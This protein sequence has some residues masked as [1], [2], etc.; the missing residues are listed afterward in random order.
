MKLGP[1]T[2]LQHNPHWQ[3]MVLQQQWLNWRQLGWA[4][5]FIKAVWQ[6]PVHMGCLSMPERCHHSPSR[7][8]SRQHLRMG[9]LWYHRTQSRKHWKDKL[10]WERYQWFKQVYN[11]RRRPRERANTKCPAFNNLQT[12]W[13]VLSLLIGREEIT[14]SCW[15]INVAQAYTG[16]NLHVVQPTQIG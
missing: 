3:S 10:W 2:T 8:L 6:Q 4:M 15:N 5:W 13:T 7:S 11:L 1:G 12:P 14:W 9:R 16:N